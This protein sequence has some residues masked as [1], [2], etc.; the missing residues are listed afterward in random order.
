MQSDDTE[1]AGFIVTDGFPSWTEYLG[2]MAQDGTCGENVILFAATNYYKCDIRVIS[3]FP[4]HD[5][6]I[7]PVQ[8]ISD[9]VQLVL[10]HVVEEHYVS[11]RPSMSG[12]H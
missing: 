2:K 1:L 7:K 3:S 8:P 10:G 11:L 4:N 6:T 5:C 9:A 12:N